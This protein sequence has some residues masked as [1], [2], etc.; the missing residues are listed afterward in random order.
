MTNPPA[1]LDADLFGVP[2]STPHTV[3]RC[4]P[5]GASR[6]DVAALDLVLKPFEP[7]V[8]VVRDR[9]H[10]LPGAAGCLERLPVFRC[11]LSRSAGS[12]ASPTEASWM[13]CTE[14][15]PC[16][17]PTA[18]ARVNQRYGDPRLRCGRHRATAVARRYGV[19]LRSVRSSLE[20]RPG[21]TP[22]SKFP[23]ALIMAFRGMVVGGVGEVLRKAGRSKRSGA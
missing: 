11:R 6:Q 3:V 17:D 1:V 4:L 23:V 8:H 20:L 22:S 14:R 2:R 19:L 9:R 18:R 5:A 12:R 10:A 13:A 21:L 16:G 7:P 15:R